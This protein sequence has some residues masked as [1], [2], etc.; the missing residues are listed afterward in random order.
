MSIP[1]TGLVDPMNR[2]TNRGRRWLILG[3]LGGVAMTWAMWAQVMDWGAA[4][5]AGLTGESRSSPDADES[6]VSCE[7]PFQQRVHPGPVV[8]LDRD[9]SDAGSI[10]SHLAFKPVAVAQVIARSLEAKT[11]TPIA[12]ALGA[13]EDCQIRYKAVRDY[14]CTFSKR[15]RIK[16]SMTPLHVL[17]MKVRTEPRSIYLKFRQPSAGREAIYIAGRNNGKVL[18]HDVGLNRLLAG[19]LHLDPTCGRAMEDCRHPISEAGIGP[20]LKTLETR[21]SSELD[22]SESVVIFRDDQTVKSRRCTM[23][24]TTHPDQRPE[25]LFYR[26]RLFIDDEIGLPIHFEA[27]DWPTSSH[28]PAEMVEEY[29]YSDLKLNVG[30]SDLDFDV[31]NKDYAFGRF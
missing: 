30:L 10:E 20:L 1:M 4:S 29:S 26:V 23:I 9:R 31:S 12:R 3:L 5:M 19:T 13:I 24:E 27:Y 2:S 11:E 28:A 18:A 14:T 8:G 22:P 7:R 17:T 15:E 25:F 16:G 6:L 21:W